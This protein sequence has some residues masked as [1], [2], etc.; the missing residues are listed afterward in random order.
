M[1]E[2]KVNF[3]ISR[4]TLENLGFY[5]SHF[6]MSVGFCS[7]IHFEIRKRMS[8]SKCTE[9]MLTN[10]NVINSNSD[11]NPKFYLLLGFSLNVGKIS[12]SFLKSKQNWIY[13]LRNFISVTEFD[14]Y[15]LCPKLVIYFTN[16]SK[17][18]CDTCLISFLLMVVRLTK[19]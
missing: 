2:F 10:R 15:L 9:R 12:H 18:E 6:S 19:R 3:F 7:E 11:S 13:L 4:F 14:V 5:M 17:F 8:T 16:S 1:D